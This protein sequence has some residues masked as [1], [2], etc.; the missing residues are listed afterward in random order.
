MKRG[1][2]YKTNT[3]GEVLVLDVLENHRVKVQFLNTS[4]IK[5]VYDYHLKK[6][7]IYDESLKDKE[8]FN[9]IFYSKDK[10]PY[11]FKVLR[12]GKNDNKKYLIYFFEI[13]FYKEVSKYDIT[14]NLV[15]I[16]EYREK[17][18]REKIYTQHCGD[19]LKILEYL[20][21]SKYKVEFLN[22]PFCKEAYKKHILEGKVDNPLVSKYY[23]PNLTLK[24]KEERDI[25][26]YIRNIYSN[27]L[28]RC[29]D[30]NSFS[31]NRYGNKGIKICEEW[32]CFE[33]FYNWYLENSKWNI[34]LK[35]KLQLD[36]DVLC[37]IKNISK[38]YSPE[39]CLLIPSELNQFL[40]S[41]SKEIGI[42]KKKDGYFFT[43]SLNK[44]EI[45]IR[46]SKFKTFEEA[47]L[48]YAE[49]KYNY[50][51]ELINKYNLPNNIKEI[52]L[53]YDFS[54]GLKFKTKE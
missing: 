54:W 53:Q 34:N 45:F 10:I 36:K 44:G 37:N 17:L 15:T 52:L 1:D 14:H 41:D 5:D 18:F 25:Y 27:L 11:K 2:I 29:Y 28:Q 24:N 23:I 51:K 9:K 35:Y 42:G 16:N 30:E 13:D 48:F 49:E 12:K 6:G 19:S 3:C 46:K 32:K 26:L 20:G 8:L 47:K 22:F 4:F 21:N 31:Y 38:I 7:A 33:N 40:K 43:L 39:T 50:W